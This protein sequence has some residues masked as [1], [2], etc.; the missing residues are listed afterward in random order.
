[1]AYGGGIPISHWAGNYKRS[2]YVL[3]TGK[4]MLTPCLT[5]GF[6]ARQGITIAAVRG[7]PHLSAPSQ[8]M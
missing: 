6:P 5:R 1:M 7:A 4:K 2:T 8:W 3:Y